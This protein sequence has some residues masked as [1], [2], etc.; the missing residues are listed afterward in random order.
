MEKPQITQHLLPLDN[1]VYKKIRKAVND[2]SLTTRGGEIVDP[3]EM[4]K[5]QAGMLELRG[6]ELLEQFE[7]SWAHN[8]F[9]QSKSMIGLSESIAEVKSLPDGQEKAALQAFL[10]LAYRWITSDGKLGQAVGGWEKINDK[11]LET[12]RDLVDQEYPKTELSN[13]KPGD[14]NNVALDGSAQDMGEDF[15]R[16]KKIAWLLTK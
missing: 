14:F 7:T 10:G 3:S 9:R 1:P 6:N 11:L 13:I 5:K 16:Y 2:G 8:D 15:E 4:L 12:N